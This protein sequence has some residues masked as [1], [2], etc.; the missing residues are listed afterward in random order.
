MPVRAW[1]RY[2]AALRRIAAL[3][4][5]VKRALWSKHAQRHVFVANSDSGT[6]S[7]L[8]ATTGTLRRATALG[9]APRALE[10]DPTRH[11][12]F[13]AN[14]GSDTVSVLDLRRARCCAPWPWAKA[15]PT[16]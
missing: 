6:V 4:Y 3:T 15:L 12:V 1:V 9:S 16:S 14:T 10:V 7:V 11:R 8:H 5:G 13:V 2:L